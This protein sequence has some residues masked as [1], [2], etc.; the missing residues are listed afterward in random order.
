MKKLNFLKWV[1][2]VFFVL[3]FFSGCETIKNNLI[4]CEDD[5][6]Y[7]LLLEA[8]KNG[9]ESF[10]ERDIVIDY[11]SINYCLAIVRNDESLCPNIGDDKDECIGIVTG[12]MKRC[13]ELDYK[14]YC[15]IGVA[16][17]K[18]DENLCLEIEDIEIKD[19]CFRYMAIV[20]KNEDFCERVEGKRNKYYCFFA[21][22]MVNKDE[23]FCEKQNDEQ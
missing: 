17:I 22:A 5:N 6:I 15:F 20:N 1:S 16:K 3:F 7:C 18:K 4:D 2:V 23:G 10:C 9:D 21:L 12:D 14:D 13:K 11:V 8:K 19:N